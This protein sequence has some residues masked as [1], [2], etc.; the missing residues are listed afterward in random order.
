MSIK[1]EINGK[2]TI[3]RELNDM[4]ETLTIKNLKFRCDNCARTKTL[5]KYET[6]YGEMNLCEK[7]LSEFHY[8]NELI[9][10]RR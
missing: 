10:Y 3:L 7:C 2:P 5:S 9:T 6:V 8:E 1:S 4:D